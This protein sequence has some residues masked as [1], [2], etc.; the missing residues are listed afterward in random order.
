[1]P[2]IRHSLATSSPLVGVERK[3]R[4]LRS[5]EDRCQEQR[6]QFLTV[7]AESLRDARIGPRSVCE[8]YP[9]AIA[10]NDPAASSPLGLRARAFSLWVFFA[11]GAR[12]FF[13]AWRDLVGVLHYQTLM[14]QLL[15]LPHFDGII[16]FSNMIY[17]PCMMSLH[18]WSDVWGVPS[19]G[20]NEN[21]RQLRLCFSICEFCFYE[22][23]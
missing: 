23:K 13:R 2:T 6:G 7:N 22:C 19:V 5:K 8:L 1:M 12:Y 20:H 16:A 15:Q 17:C 18:V 9:P 10:R 3:N 21:A 14:R 4:Q 11:R